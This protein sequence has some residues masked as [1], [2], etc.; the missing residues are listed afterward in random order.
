MK[1]LKYAVIL[2]NVVFL[3][4]VGAEAF[5]K[6]MEGRAVLL[7]LFAFPI[8]NLIFVFVYRGVAEESLLALWVRAKK[9]DLQARLNGRTSAP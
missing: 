9:A 5:T 4:F 7:L 3:G 1:G 2:S 6:G 8:I